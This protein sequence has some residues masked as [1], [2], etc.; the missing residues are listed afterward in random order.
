MAL[1][2]PGS[3]R[4]LAPPLPFAAGNVG[5]TGLEETSATE[6]VM[7]A[8]AQSDKLALPP[9]VPRAALA[10][11]TD[12]ELAVQLT[13][14]QAERDRRHRVMPAAGVSGDTDDGQTKTC[15]WFAC[16]PSCDNLRE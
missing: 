1:L 15:S 3:S 13:A 11:M 12:D 14:L 7:A 2:I 9:A 16:A 6:S 10:A 4:A 8:H 5:P